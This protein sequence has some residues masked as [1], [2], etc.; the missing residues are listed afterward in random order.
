MVDCLSILR[1]PSF[2][3]A[4]KGKEGISITELLIVIAVLAVLMVVFL[5]AF[6]PWTQQA[7]ARDSRRKSDLQ[8]LK[9]PLED[10]YNDNNCYP[11]RLENLVPDYIGEEPKD[12]DTGAPYEYYRLEDDCDKYW[13]YTEL[14]FFQ[15]EEIVEVGCGAGCGPGGDEGTGEA[16]EEKCI[17][18]YGVC[19]GGVS[20]EGCME[21]CA[22]ET[23]PICEQPESQCDTALPGAC[24]PG[25]NYQLVCYSDGEIRCCPIE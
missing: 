2:A 17:Y 6:K 11:L 13:I 3:K 24:C 9:A 15:D 19:S 4:T 18:N 1:K 12:P 21:K 22:G 14:E 8:K 7:K 16:G 5:A 20:L 23:N 25:K 10:Y